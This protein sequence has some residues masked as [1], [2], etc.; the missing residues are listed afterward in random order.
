V[1]PETHNKSTAVGSYSVR[2]VL[3]NTRSISGPVLNVKKPING[4]ADT[5][6]KLFT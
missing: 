2:G 6:S 3:K 4:F 1:W 5:I